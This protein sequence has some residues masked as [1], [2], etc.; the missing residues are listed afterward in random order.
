MLEPE[1]MSAKPTPE[2]FPA[3]AGN[4]QSQNLTPASG[5]AVNAPATGAPGVGRKWERW[6][7]NTWHLLRGDDEIAAVFPSSRDAGKWWALVADP[8][9][10]DM[11]EFDSAGSAMAA[12]DS[13]LSLE[14]AAK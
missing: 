11:G 13:H 12:V 8:V 6:V 10:H 3:A 7:G 9:L 4:S 1:I 2:T 5:V 14:R